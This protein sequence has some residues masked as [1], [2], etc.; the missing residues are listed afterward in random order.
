MTLSDLKYKLIS[1]INQTDDNDILEEL[2]RL[3]TIDESEFEVIKLSSEQKSAIKT[4]QNQYKNNQ[5]LTQKQV[6]IT[7]DHLLSN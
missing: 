6:D 3:L 7:L 5:F 4:A 1:K 2:Y